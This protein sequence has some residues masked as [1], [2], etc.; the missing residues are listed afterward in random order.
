MKSSKIRLGNKPIL[1]KQI[2]VN[3]LCQAQNGNT[4]NWINLMKNYFE[5]NKHTNNSKLICKF[6]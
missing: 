2:G 6:N 3:I 4:I 5:D 1:T